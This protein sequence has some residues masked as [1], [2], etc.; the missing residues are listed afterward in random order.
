MIDADQFI[1]ST[2]RNWFFGGDDTGNVMS[3]A[4]IRSLW[5]QAERIG[6]VMLVTGDG[7]ISCSHNP[8]EQE[9]IVA[10]L[11]YCEAVAGIGMLQYGGGAGG[12]MVLKTFTLFEH[13]SVGL[14]Y[15]LGCCFGEVWVSKPACS[16][17]SNAETYL[18]CKGEHLFSC[19][20]LTQ[21]T[22][23]SLVTVLDCPR[24]RLSVAATAD[25]SSG[26]VS[27][28]AF[29]GVSRCPSEC[30]DFKGIKE[31]YLERLLAFAG[32]D[33]P[34]DAEGRP[35]A[36]VPPETLPATFLSEMQ[37]MAAKFSGHFTDAILRN[38][39]L[40][41]N[42][43]GRLERQI[44]SEAKGEVAR[45]FRQV[46]QLRELR[47]LS[48][49]IVYEQWISGTE[50]NTGLR[51]SSAHGTKR[52]GDGSGGTLADRQARFDKDRKD[53]QLNH[54]DAG[55]EVHRGQHRDKRARRDGADAASAP[56]QLAAGGASDP[57][58]SQSGGKGSLDAAADVGASYSSAAQK[59]M[60]MMG[61][62]AG[63]GLGAKGQGR[64]AP[65]AVEERQQRVGLGFSAH[66]VADASLGM[67][68]APFFHDKDGPDP[69]E[70]LENRH[71]APL[72]AEEVDGWRSIV[73]PALPAVSMSKFCRPS[74]IQALQEARREHL[75]S[76][77][78]SLAANDHLAPALF[79]N[80]AAVV[81]HRETADTPFCFPDSALVMAHLD[82]TFGLLGTIAPESGPLPFAVLSPCVDGM[83]EYVVRKL[84]DNSLGFVTSSSE[85]SSRWT[86]ADKAAGLFQL[87]QAADRLCTGTQVSHAVQA[88]RERLA[89]AGDILLVVG[90]IQ[91]DVLAQVAGHG[92]GN[93][94]RH[95]KRSALAQVLTAL[96]LLAEG[97]TF[98][99]QLTDLFSRFSVGLVNVLYRSFR[100]VR[101]IKPFTCDPLQ[102]RCLVVCT[103]CMPRSEP[104]IGHLQ[105][106]VETLEHL[107]EGYDILSFV[108]MS[109]L[110][111][112]GFMRHVTMAVERFVQR[113][114]A[115][116]ASVTRLLEEKPTE[117]ALRKQAD[118]LG[119]NALALIQREYASEAAGLQ[120][121]EEFV[122]M[123][124]ERD[125]VVAVV[126]RQPVDP[127]ATDPT[128]EASSER[129]VATDPQLA[130][131]QQ[132]PAPTA[133]AEEQQRSA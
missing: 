89:G 3:A 35:L 117:E 109:N 31:E 36:F 55:A 57:V 18:V 43:M 41:E 50:L 119:E 131:N 86:H 11:H 105:S 26:R 78:D 88:V 28:G 116:I 130:L 38:L 6:K 101:L 10:Q 125:A 102:P 13:C 47:K 72:G 121:A 68:G 108:P 96:Q 82:M 39:D 84:G 27:H 67:E 49:R 111:S 14:L 94:E 56:S 29:R 126:E 5:Q 77:L 15:F 44:I 65:V 120:A 7:S 91:L 73:A 122:R 52:K 32:P 129:N 69:H 90:G 4:N 19:W 66:L 63:A 118:A 106:A 115:S 59:M 124:E 24:R 75:P 61:Y 97:G 74:I 64:T 20:P 104:L 2:D 42:G 81:R 112:T 37:E 71:D 51:V 92:K 76:V 99:F 107:Q 40:D 114:T 30:A 93:V 100:R 79:A 127:V 33:T 8:N 21:R 58:A 45:T 34:R 80:H 25:P 132:R 46:Y 17:A 133:A 60:A 123:E 48:H 70:W 113:E 83:G 22:N 54:G 62:T 95:G 110:L 12:A 103:G 87:E 128:R 9:A 53:R 85:V 16:T 1:I 98:V 23:S